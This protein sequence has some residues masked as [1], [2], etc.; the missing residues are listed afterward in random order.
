MFEVRV[1]GRGGQGVVTAAQLLSAAAFIDGQEAQAF[2]SFRSERTG[3]PV[4]SFCRMDEAPIRVH[5]PVVTPDVVVVLDSTL[6]HHVP[7]FEG[8]VP[9][10]VVLINSASST[11]D[12]GLEDLLVCQGHSHVVAVDASELARVHLGR[13]LP[14][15]CLLGAFCALTGRIRMASLEAAVRQRFTGETGAANIAAAQASYDIVSQ[16]FARRQIGP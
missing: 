13:P 8:L 15:I 12:L 5:E 2:T 11:H 1:H 10:G 9:S 4:V 14:N 6:L 7:V 16:A 3:T